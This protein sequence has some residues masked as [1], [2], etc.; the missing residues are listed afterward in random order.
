MSTKES[1]QER[2][3][4]QKYLNRESQMNVKVDEL[5]FDTEQIASEGPILDPDMPPVLGPP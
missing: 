5:A 1:L 4:R 3:F 2:T